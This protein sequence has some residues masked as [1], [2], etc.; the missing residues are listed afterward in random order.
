MSLALIPHISDFIACYKQNLHS[1]SWLTLEYEKKLTD[2]SQYILTTLSINEH[3][4][5]LNGNSNQSEVPHC[6][7]RPLSAY[8]SWELISEW[9]QKITFFFLFI[10]LKKG[11]LPSSQGLLCRSP[12]CQLAHSALFKLMDMGA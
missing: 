12:T 4:C 2:W 11:I 5:K 10:F 6:I 9:V 7:F 1:F 3:P 8:N